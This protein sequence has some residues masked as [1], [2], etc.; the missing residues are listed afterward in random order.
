VDFFWP[1]ERLVVEIDG[2]AFHS[3]KPKFE[4]DRRR[5]A[6]LAAAGLRVVRIT[7]RQLVDEPEAVLVRL[8][9]TLART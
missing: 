1:T 6:E 5:D 8:A 9:L 4:K 2:F 3:S 7:W